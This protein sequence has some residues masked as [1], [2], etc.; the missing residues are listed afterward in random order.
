MSQ[1]LPTFGSICHRKFFY[2]LCVNALLYT[3]Y[4]WHL[5]G[6]GQYENLG[7]ILNICLKNLIVNFVFLYPLFYLLAFIPH[8]SYLIWLFVAIMFVMG[9]VDTLLIT[10]FQT[11]LNAI[12]LDIFFSSNTL[13]IKEFTAF[14]G[15]GNIDI[16]LAFCLFSILF[17]LP[18][19]KL[20]RLI[21]I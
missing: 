17:L 9:L 7:A 2:I 10:T 15:A 20:L 5:T 3:L 16:I 18:Y 12:F 13:E 14:Y 21:S 19:S 4:M 1:Y 6:G 8:S 11:P